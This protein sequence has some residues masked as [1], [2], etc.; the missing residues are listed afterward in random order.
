MKHKRLWWAL[1][2]VVVSSFAV[3]TREGG[4]IEKHMPPIPSRVVT[5]EGVVVT[6]GE[7]IRRGQ[8]VWQSLGGQ[9]VGSIWGHGAYQAPDWSADW[10]HRESEHVLNAWA[11]AEGATGYQALPAERQAAL[12]ERLAGVMRTTIGVQQSGR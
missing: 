5:T 9:Q 4:Q 3:L 10:L 7:A 8:N 1:A 12:K 6:D 2:L 11:M